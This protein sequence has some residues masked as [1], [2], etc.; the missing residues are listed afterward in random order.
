MK[1]SLNPMRKT[2]FW[3][4][5]LSITL[6]FALQPVLPAYAMATTSVE[7][8]DLPDG[9]TLQVG[10]EVQFRIRFSCTTVGA[11]DCDNVNIQTQLPDWWQAAAITLSSSAPYTNVT[12]SPTGLVTINDNQNNPVNAERLDPGESETVTVRLRIRDSA[13]TDSGAIPPANAPGTVSTTV[14]SNAA[15][16]TPPVDSTLNLEPPDFQWSTTKTRTLP[17]QSGGPEPALDQPVTYRVCVVSDSAT[18]NVILNDFQLVDTFPVGATVLSPAA[19]GTNPAVAIA[20]NQITFTWTGQNRSPSA[21]QLC[22]NIRL[23]YPSPGF[24]D[25][26]NANAAPDVTNNVDLNVNDPTGVCVNP[27]DSAGTTHGFDPEVSTPGL[28]KV[29]SQNPVGINGIG[30][31]RLRA[32]TSNANAPTAAFIVMDEM[33]FENGP[34]TTPNTAD[35]VLP[36]EVTSIIIPRWNSPGGTDVRGTFQVSSSATCR[37]DTTGAAGWTTLT[38]SPFDGSSNP[39]IAAPST[40]IRCIRATFEQSDDGGGTWNPGVPMGF[41]FQNNRRL[42]ILFEVRNNDAARIGETHENCMYVTSRVDIAD[43]LV[44]TAPN[45][46]T[47]QISGLTNNVS[48]D[49]NKGVTPNNPRPGDTVTIRLEMNITERAS[50]NLQSPQIADAIPDNIL[51]DPA[52]DF[53][54]ISYNNT[55]GSDVTLSEADIR[56]GVGGSGF[57]ITTENLVSPAETR[58]VIRFD[59]VGLDI[60]PPPTGEKRLRIEITGTIRPATP[61]SNYT[62]NAFFVDNGPGELV[63]EDTSTGTNPGTV[64]D[65]NDIFGSGNTTQ[66]CQTNTNYNVPSTARFAGQKWLRNEYN[67]ADEDRRDN[68]VVAPGLTGTCEDG[69]TETNGQL[70]EPNY[71]RNPCVHEGEYGDIFTYRLTIQNSGNVV[72]YDYHLYDILPYQGDTGITLAQVGTARDSEW[73]PIM[74]ANSITFVDSERAPLVPASNPLLTAGDFIIEY[75]NSRTPCR[76]ELGAIPGCTAVVWQTDPTLAPIN[77][78]ENVESFRIR[79][80][81]GATGWAPGVLVE[82]LVEME[83]PAENYYGGGDIQ[84]PEPGGVA[85]NNYGHNFYEAP[86]QNAGDLLA[87]AEPPRVGI[88]VRQRGSIGNFVWFDEGAGA[89]FNNS[90]FDPGE[91]PVSGV[92]V[93]L[94]RDVNGNNTFDIGDALVT[95]TITG[96]PQTTDAGA[97]PGFYLFDNLPEGTYFVRIP[98]S[99]FGAGG[100]LHRYMS[101]TDTTTPVDATQDE[102]DHGID[103]PSPATNGINSPPIVLRYNTEETGEG[104][105]TDPN[106]GPTF[107]GNGPVDDNNSDLTVDFGFVQVFDWGDNPDSYGT[108][109]DPATTVNPATDDS[110]EVGPSH[111]IISELRLG[112]TEDAEGSGQPAAAGANSNGDDTNGTGNDEDGVN[113]PT[114]VAGQTQTVEVTVYNN[115]G[116]PA[117]L[118]GW[119]DWDGSGSYTAAD[120]VTVTVPS[121]ATPQVISVPVTVP[122]SVTNGNIYTRWRLTTDSINGNNPTGPA[123]D[124]EVEDYQVPTRG[125]GV[126][127]NKT[128]GQNSIVAGQATTYT[129]TVQNSNAAT[130][131]ADF[132]D[133]LPI[134]DPNGFDPAT[135]SWTCVGS[136]GATCQHPNSAAAQ[137]NDGENPWEINETS[138]QIPQNGQLTYSVTGTLRANAGLGANIVNTANLANVANCQNTPAS[139]DDTNGVIFD[140]PSGTKIGTVVNGTTIRWTMVWLNTGAVAQQ[141]TVSDVLQAGQTFA[142]N[143]VCTP[144][145]ASTT[146]LPIADNCTYNAGT[147]TVLWNGNIGPAAPANANRVEIAFDVTVAGNANYN[148]SAAINFPALAQSASANANVNLDPNAPGGVGGGGDNPDDPNNPLLALGDPAISKFGSPLF[149]QPGEEVVWTIIV[150]NPGNVPFNNV[151]VTDNMPPQFEILDN[152]STGG[153]V[154]VAGQSYTLTAP[155]LNPGET[156]TITLRTRMRGNPLPPPFFGQGEVGACVANGPQI[157][158]NR[159][160]LQFDGGAEA[161]A[162]AT[163]ACLPDALPATGESELNEWRLPVFSLTI[164]VLSI[165]ILGGMLW[166]RRRYPLI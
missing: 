136:G 139:D 40:D 83:I 112:A 84:N 77:G 15:T 73:R 12:L 21:G 4:F 80:N 19:G 116:R 128:D 52:T 55:V 27:C 138:V 117:N 60:A 157:V 107:I 85:W 33:P 121:S 76:P 42:E 14:T 141:A 69:Q 151:L 29:I 155:V 126:S 57:S 134:A 78:W 62:N 149:A 72:L 48:V 17:S 1:H 94:Y 161:C 22:Q 123:S 132:T 59:L 23:Q 89:N 39:T 31:W 163:V 113:H 156:I 145:G 58:Q 129:I 104:T 119:L 158:L 47:V 35:D 36:L 44:T 26:T 32:N 103:N 108:D 142:G 147:N 109:N 114:F 144:F 105:S 16:N 159:A 100:P 13:Y 41:S 18:D 125:P 8:L 86:G 106:D 20:G 122:G 66:I 68:I 97:N 50:A 34:D 150:T 164:V 124:G 5:L 2:S 93:E 131:E 56:A 98:P 148:N 153:T 91:T 75:S 160:C 127:V 92:R 162:E 28:N 102:R 64:N 110:D 30:R 9:T 11:G 61:A 7:I 152:N 25:P 87:A 63:C 46:A 43:P 166:I 130:C 146:T 143:L 133:N 24:G 95:D 120:A 74:R 99:N 54:D 81:N 3:L 137:A 140:P 111:L 53:W 118:V 37:T 10:Q 165:A 154:T 88:M 135:I 90:R 67:A 51:I 96:N 6:V 70:A 65:T 45:C 38:G 115:T 101:S 71:S 82:F 49:T 79:L